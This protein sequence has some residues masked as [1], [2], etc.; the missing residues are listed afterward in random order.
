MNLVFS[1]DN[2]NENTSSQNKH[3]EL[4]VNTQCLGRALYHRGTNKHSNCQVTWQKE[5][6]NQ[7]KY[8]T[9][10]REQLSGGLESNGSSVWPSLPHT[11]SLE[12]H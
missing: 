4:Y 12:L 6:N 1:L 11:A 9:A 7:R 2:D 10:S 5:R 3:C 8:N